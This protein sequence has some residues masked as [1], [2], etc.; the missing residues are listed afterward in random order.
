MALATSEMGQTET[1]GP[2]RARSALPPTTDVRR[3]WQ[4]VRLVPEPDLVLECPEYRRHQASQLAV[5]TGQVL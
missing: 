2:I 5:S 1:S 4:H 3:L